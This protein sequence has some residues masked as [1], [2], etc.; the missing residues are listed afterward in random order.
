MDPLKELKGLLNIPEGM[1][2]EE[3]RKRRVDVMQECICNWGDNE[4]R[5]IRAELFTV[6]GCVARILDAES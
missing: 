3:A 5:K 6:W 1:T 4:T 2:A